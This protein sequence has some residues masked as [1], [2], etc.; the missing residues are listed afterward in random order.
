MHD[1]NSASK[2]FL[3]QRARERLLTKDKEVAKVVMAKLYIYDVALIM[4]I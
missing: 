2:S 1:E 4:L 3:K